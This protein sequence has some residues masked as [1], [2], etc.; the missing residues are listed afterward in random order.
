MPP[1]DGGL[2][3]GIPRP[4]NGG[5]GKSPMCEGLG[6]V[7]YGVDD[8]RAECIPVIFLGVARGSDGIS[9]LCGVPRMDTNPSVAAVVPGVLALDIGARVI[10][11]PCA[12]EAVMGP[13]PAGVH[14]GS[15]PSRGLVPGALP[16]DKAGRTVPVV[17]NAGFGAS[18]FS[19]IVKRNV[20]LN[21]LLVSAAV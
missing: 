9:L 11:F 6:R 14:P 8:A 20:F 18:S 1:V 13:D 16:A 10:G 2:G 19:G 12:P 15:R 7:G 3:P 5:P 17:P 4:L 21:F